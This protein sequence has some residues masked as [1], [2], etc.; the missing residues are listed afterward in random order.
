MKQEVVTYSQSLTQ[1]ISVSFTCAHCDTLNIF[2]QDIVGVGNLSVKTLKATEKYVPSVAD[3]FAV[4][5]LAKEDL[6]LK[7][8]KIEKKIATDNFSWLN[9]A[10]C[11]KCKHFQSWNNRRIWSDFLK[12]FF[13][14]PFMVLLVVGYPIS[15]I[16]KNSSDFPLW[17]NLLLLGLIIIVMVGAIINLVYSLLMKSRKSHNKPT[18]TLLSIR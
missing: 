11:S 17:A 3:T 10:K 18:V 4:N 13:G 5:N 9:K 1:P 7:M 12:L 15:Q 14:A 2:T 6:A 16:Y 8:K